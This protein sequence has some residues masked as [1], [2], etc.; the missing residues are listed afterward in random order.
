MATG[1]SDTWNRGIFL[2]LRTVMH[3]VAAVHYGYGIYY[4]FM[5]VYPPK[6]HVAY[7]AMRSFGGKFRYLT[8]LGVVCIIQSARQSSLEKN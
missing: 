1:S 7:D 8:I 2:A 5:F 6:D 4:D 3:V